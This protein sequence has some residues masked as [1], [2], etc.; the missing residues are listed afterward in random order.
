MLR[1]ALSLPYV[2][3]LG[4]LAA[5]VLLLWLWLLGVS[6]CELCGQAALTVA[7]HLRRRP[8]PA[9]ENALRAAFADLDKELA[10][11]LGD[12]TVPQRAD[13]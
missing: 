9:V 1:H 13:D 12:R 11:V 5:G 7:G 2:V 8:D 3:V 4:M 10:A 6:L